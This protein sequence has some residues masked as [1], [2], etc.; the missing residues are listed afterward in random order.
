M[1]KIAICD[2]EKDACEVLRDKILNYMQEKKEHCKIECFFSAAALLQTSCAYDMFLLDI[3]MPEQDGLTLARKIRANESHS[4]IIFITALAEYVYEA[5]EVEAFDYICKPIEDMRLHKVFNRALNKLRTNEN[6]SLFIQTMNWCKSVKLDDV[7]F[8][9]VINRKIYLHTKN[10]VIEYYSKLRD[11]EKELDFRFVRC[12][13]SYLVNLDY[14]LE[15]TNGQI[16]LE[17]G[18]K[19]PTS[20][21]RHRDFMDAMMLYMKRKGT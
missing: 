6:K 17:N 15:Y 7:Y 13:R 20:R 18:E 12:H 14:L 8:C 19:V 21:L 2:D 16:I 4:I 10:G 11:I 5:F 3:Q 9:E 1:I